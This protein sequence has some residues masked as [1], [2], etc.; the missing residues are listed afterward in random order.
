VH[1]KKKML[2]NLK[3]QYEKHIAPPDNK[4]VKNCSSKF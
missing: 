4:Q 2:G 3:G 1:G